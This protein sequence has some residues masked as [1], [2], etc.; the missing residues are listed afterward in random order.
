MKTPKT[1]THFLKGLVA[2]SKYHKRFRN[3]SIDSYYLKFSETDPRYKEKPSFSDEIVFATGMSF[4]MILVRPFVCGYMESAASH[5]NRSGKFGKYL[6]S[7]GNRSI[8]RKSVKVL[9]VA[10]HNMLV[11]QYLLGAGVGGLANLYE[12]MF[13]KESEYKRC[14]QK[15]RK[16]IQL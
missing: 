15:K 6:V 2:G 11:V 12:L 10:V 4:G 9:K 16:E 7:S 5:D 3:E 8:R 1:L 13:V 14:V